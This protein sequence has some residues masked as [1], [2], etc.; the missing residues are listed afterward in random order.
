MHLF[1]VRVAEVALT[2]QVEGCNV[3]VGERGKLVREEDSISI[4]MN[5]EVVYCKLVESFERFVSEYSGWEV[6]QF[7]KVM[8]RVCPVVWLQ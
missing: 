7:L 6:F 2:Q 5:I 3:S 1:E 4:V 8:F